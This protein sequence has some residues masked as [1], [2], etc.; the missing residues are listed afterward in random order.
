[1]TEPPEHR[2]CTVVDDFC[3]RLLLDCRGPAVAHQQVR[4]DDDTTDHR[5]VQRT[6]SIARR[7]FA[8]RRGVLGRE[9]VGQPGERYVK[10]TLIWPLLDALDYEYRIE[11]YLG[12]TDKQADFR[13]I[14]TVEPLL[15]E[16]KAPND[17]KK[18]VADIREDVD[19]P[20][21]DARFALVTDGFNWQLLECDSDRTRTR[22]E[23]LN[24]IDIRALVASRLHL[25]GIRNPHT[26]VRNVTTEATVSIGADTLLETDSTVVAR[27]FAE[28]FSRDAIDAAIESHT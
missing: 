8:G 20:D 9:N 26:A 5:A 21:V 12:S 4:E 3:D 28:R 11:S 13:T 1:M 2:I 17:F 23:V 27:T 24:E 15:G 16:A 7:L 14:N 6:T 25:K 19:L 10:E 22:T 18:A